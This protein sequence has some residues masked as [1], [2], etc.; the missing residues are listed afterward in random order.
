MANN[1][2]QGLGDRG[3]RYEVR[4][5]RLGSGD[6]SVI[7]W[8]NAADGGEM[9]RRSR[10]NP[11]FLSSSVRVVDRF[12]GIEKILPDWTAFKAGCRK[13]IGQ[14]MGGKA[15]CAYCSTRFPLKPS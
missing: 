11:R 2:V 3:Q 15:A 12:P 4:A 5:K 9:L 1:V 14:L 10:E 7:G 13:C 8:L 6:E